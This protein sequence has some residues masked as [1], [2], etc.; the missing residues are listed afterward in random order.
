MKETKLIPLTEFV[1]R[2]DELVPIEKSRSKIDHVYNKYDAIVRYAAFLSQLLKLEYLVPTDDEGNVLEYPVNNGSFENDKLC[3]YEKAQSKV[4]FEGFEVNMFG[5]VS[6]EE[7]T[8]FYRKTPNA[9]LFKNDSLPNIE[10]LIDCNVKIS[11]T[12][13]KQIYG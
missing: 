13:L 1:N 4:L 3:E 9:G 11:E 6:N 2:I 7:A 8:P 10:S 5:N 12:A